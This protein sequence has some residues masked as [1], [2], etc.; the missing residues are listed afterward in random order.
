MPS[1]AG[2]FRS[3]TDAR[4]LPIPRPPPITT[5]CPSPFQ[6]E[7]PVFHQRLDLVLA[8]DEISETGVY[9]LEPCFRNQT[10]PPLPTR[11]WL[12]NA[13]ELMTAEVAQMERSPSSL[14]VG[15]A[16]K[17]PHRGLRRS[18]CDALLFA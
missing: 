1:Q 9:R 8:A 18:R 15:A 7:T 16:R 3:A 14:R 10:R 5:I 6:G 13:I 2:G 11:G 17:L 4:D 12:G